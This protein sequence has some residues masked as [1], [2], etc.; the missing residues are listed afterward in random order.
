MCYNHTTLQYSQQY[1]AFTNFTQTNLL[2]KNPVSMFMPTHCVATR[3]NSQSPIVAYAGPA[4][5]IEPLS[6]DLK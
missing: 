3:R 6:R 5:Y 1:G 2:L 4:K